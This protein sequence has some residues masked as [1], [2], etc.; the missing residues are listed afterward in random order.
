MDAA[1]LWSRKCAL[2]SLGSSMGQCGTLLLSLPLLDL[3][4]KSLGGLL[5]SLLELS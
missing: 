3:S 5:L 4:Q 1:S 2:G